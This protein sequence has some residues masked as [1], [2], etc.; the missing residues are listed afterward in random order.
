MLVFFVTPRDMM[1]RHF[2][3]FRD[4]SS[5]DTHFSFTRNDD[6]F[7]DISQDISST[8]ASFSSLASLTFHYYYIIEDIHIIFIYISR[9]TY[10]I[11]LSRQP[12]F[13]TNARRNT[14]VITTYWLR[15]VAALLLFRGFTA[16][17]FYRPRSCYARLGPRCHASYYMMA[18]FAT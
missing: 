2:Y 6:Y 18:C 12:L 5:T 11:S 8:Y 16:K 3:A 7:A 1:M 13:S 17:G 15:R 14:Y 4:D 9:R 10:A